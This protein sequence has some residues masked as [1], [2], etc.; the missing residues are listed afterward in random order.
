MNKQL[1]TLEIVFPKKKQA[2]LIEYTDPPLGKTQ[3]RGRTLATCISTGSEIAAY[4]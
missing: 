2:K 3:L 4:K 1:K